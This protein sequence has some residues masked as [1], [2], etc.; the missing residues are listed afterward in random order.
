MS[1][2]GNDLQV[3]RMIKEF[4][5][6]EETRSY[7]KPCKYQHEDFFERFLPSAYLRHRYRYTGTSLL[8]ERDRSLHL[9]SPVLQAEVADI[10]RSHGECHQILV[11][12]VSLQEEHIPL[13]PNIPEGGPI[14]SMGS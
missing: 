8:P 9:P 12:R 13:R 14:A 1:D 10:L 5:L 7:L 11:A 2:I 6:I 3:P 4:T